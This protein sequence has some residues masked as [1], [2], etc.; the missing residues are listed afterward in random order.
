[1]F[2]AIAASGTMLFNQPISGWNVSNVTNM[3]FMFGAQ[4]ESGNANAHNFNQPIG[5]WDIS[6]VTNMNFMFGNSGTTALAK[7]LA[8]NQ[9][10]SSWDLN[11][12]CTIT[13]FM[14]N[15]I[16]SMSQ[17]NYSRTLTGWANKVADVFSGPFAVAPQFTSLVYNTTAYQPASRFSNAAD[18]RAYLVAARAL[19]VS[20]AS[21]ANG[22]GSYP[23]N[24]ATGAYINSLGWYFLKSGSTWTLYDATN[25]A[26]ATGTGNF[27]WEVDVWTG[28]LSAGTVLSSGAGWTITGDAAV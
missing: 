17:E 15:R 5:S 28:V 9:D 26:Q 13:G 3:S 24:V 25:A 8:F 16:P 2:A 23:L 20:G 1:M 18:A 19:S 14:R 11:P 10:L 7:Q 4:T 12:A 27:P 6:K 21:D 22:N